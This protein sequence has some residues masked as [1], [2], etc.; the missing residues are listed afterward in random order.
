MR[1]PTASSSSGIAQ[2]LTS[3]QPEDLPQGDDLHRVL[4]AAAG[5]TRYEAEGA[6]ALSLTRHNA[7]RPEAIWELKAQ[8]LKKSNLLTLHRGQETFADLGGLQTLK[9]FCRRALAPRR[10]AVKPRGILLLSPSGLRQVAPSARPWATRW[11][12]RR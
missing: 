6:F 2:E 9:D 12:G 4:D 7:F 1:C 10:S 8:T 5:L 3:D 11:A